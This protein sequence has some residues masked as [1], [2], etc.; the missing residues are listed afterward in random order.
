MNPPRVNDNFLE[1]SQM[2]FIFE[3]K[4]PSSKAGSPLNGLVKEN[5]EVNIRYGYVVF[6]MKIVIKKH[7]FSFCGCKLS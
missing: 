7:T 4:W 1:P 3:N 6:Y 2:L 5:T